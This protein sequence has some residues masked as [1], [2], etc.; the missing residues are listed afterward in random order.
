MMQLV[1]PGAWRAG[2][3]AIA[4]TLGSGL[5]AAQT[6]AAHSPMIARNIRNVFARHQRMTALTMMRP[7][8]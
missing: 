7:V 4:L 8:D 5:A 6:P 1:T 2:L 3:I